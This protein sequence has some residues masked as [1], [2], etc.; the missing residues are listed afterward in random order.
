MIDSRGS[1]YLRNIRCQF[2]EKNV[3]LR[4]HKRHT[5]RR[6]ASARFADGRG[7]GDTPSSIGQAGVVSHPVLD[8][9]GTTSSLGWEGTPIKS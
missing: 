5:T 2:Y 9:E 6:V 4:E 7:G 8:G 3:L 1:R